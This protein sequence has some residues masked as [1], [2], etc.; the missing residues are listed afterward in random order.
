MRLGDGKS[1]VGI[2]KDEVPGLLATES[3]VLR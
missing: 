3:G 1:E 2:L